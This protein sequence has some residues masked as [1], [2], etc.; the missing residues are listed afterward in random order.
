VEEEAE[1]AKYEGC[2]WEGPFRDGDE[3]GASIAAGSK[4]LS[5]MM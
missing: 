4:W 1:G 3:S 2:F 5:G